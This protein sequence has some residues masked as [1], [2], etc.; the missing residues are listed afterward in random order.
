MVGKEGKWGGKDRK[1]GT[2]HVVV[3]LDWT[4]GGQG[5]KEGT[6]HVV[7]S[8]DWKYRQDTTQWQYVFTED[9]FSALLLPVC[10]SLTHHEL[11]KTDKT[12]RGPCGLQ[13]ANHLLPFPRTTGPIAS[14]PKVSYCNLSHDVVLLPTPTNQ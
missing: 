11:N 1:E 4:M 8:P 7:V 12:A 9:V 3:S 10:Y 5:K 6:K 13:K 2:K 14:P